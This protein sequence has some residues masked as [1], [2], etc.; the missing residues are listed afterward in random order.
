MN[1]QPAIKIVF[2]LILFLAMAGGL[3]YLRFDILDK[4]NSA[5]NIKK[6]IN[7]Y[8]QIYEG[9]N[10]LRSDINKIKPYLLELNNFV[11]TKDQLVNFNK[12]I[13]IIANQNQVSVVSNFSDE[14]E[15]AQSGLK[16]IGVAINANGNLENLINFLKTIEKSNYSVKL[17]TLDFSQTDKEYKATLNGI[18]FYAEANQ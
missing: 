15:S 3:I 18:M 10:L 13:K 7:S 14:K 5:E 1:H 2:W 6:D 9:S 8:S 17:N 12:D 16:E 4:I 11:Q